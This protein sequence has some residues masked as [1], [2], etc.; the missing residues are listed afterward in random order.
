MPMMSVGRC[1]GVHARPLL[2]RRVRLGGVLVPTPPN[3]ADAAQGGLCRA[4]FG[5]E[6]KSLSE[7]K[8]PAEDTDQTPWL[9]KTLDTYKVLIYDILSVAVI[10]IL[11]IPVVVFPVA[12]GYFGIT[13]IA[14]VSHT[15]STFTHCLGVSIICLHSFHNAIYLS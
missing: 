14:R 3:H 1:V 7:T 12:F 10:F 15:T 13:F 8:E 5:E 6:E 2:S 11:I 9:E 4:S